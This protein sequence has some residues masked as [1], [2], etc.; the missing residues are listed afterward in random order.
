M[1]VE[2]QAVAGGRRARPADLIGSPGLPGAR[3]KGLERWEN[4][5]LPVYRALPFV[6]LAIATVVLFVDPPAAWPYL[7]GTLVIAFVA[8]TWV[9]ILHTRRPPL[10]EQAPLGVVYFVGL[11]VFAGVLV[12]IAPWYGIFAWVGYVQAATVLPGRWR[13]VGVVATAVVMSIS[14]NGGLH[15]PTPSAI[16]G[17]AVM[18]VVNCMLAG[19]ML[20]FA[21][22]GLVQHERRKRMV[23]ELAEANDKL[24]TALAENA[25]LH[26]QLLT[27]A[28]EAGVLDERQ[29]MAREIHDTIAQGLTG[30]ITQL[31]AARQAHHDP[32][33][34]SRHLD[35]AIRL[36]RES[37]SEAR[38]SVHAVRPE[39]LDVARLPEALAEVGRRWAEV[40]GIAAQV[41]T[42]GTVR[43]LH[44]EVEV[45]VLRVAQE[46]LTNVAKHAQATRVGVTLSYMEDVVTLDVRDNGVGFIPGL[47]D[48]PT[49]SATGDGHQQG[50]FGLVAMRQR[51]HR[52]AGRLEVESEP[53]QGTAISATVPAIVGG[54]A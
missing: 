38:R 22:V 48:G 51:V 14:N 9:F 42:T 36:A 24:R 33:E 31:E 49:A 27:Q 1:S 30:V 39:A 25:G 45:T 37:L 50:G 26:A 29:R 18:F 47:P 5:E 12:A 44:P 41:T 34:W 4:L 2:D 11:I 19:T 3:P 7:P 53:G 28:R 10:V 43:A 6:T 15:E 8:A 46:A 35:T 13:Y 17:Y 16:T 20:F 40:N 32:V 23:A 21:D 54:P 52:L